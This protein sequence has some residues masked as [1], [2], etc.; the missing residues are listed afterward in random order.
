MA[1]AREF[2]N[3]TLP[4]IFTQGENG[5]DVIIDI[6]FRMIESIFRMAAPF[7]S[8]TPDISGLVWEP[9]LMGILLNLYKELEEPLMV[10]D[11]AGSLEQKW[12]ATFRAEVRE[13]SSLHRI[14]VSPEDSAPEEANSSSV[15]YTFPDGSVAW[16]AS[17]TNSAP[18]AAV[19]IV[20]EHRSAPS[21][22]RRNGHGRVSLISFNK[23]R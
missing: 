13:E 1:C 8:S 12:T 11:S 23:N 18:E 10:R 5:S 9:G 16:A 2:S 15:R 21:R 7:S 14:T 3:W 19:A 6:P 4:V 20:T 22:K 17:T